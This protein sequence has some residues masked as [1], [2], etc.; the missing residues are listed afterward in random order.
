[1][2]LNFLKYLVIIVITSIWQSETIVAQPLSNQAVI[3]NSITNYIESDPDRFK[4]PNY[5]AL[6]LDGATSSSLQSLQTVLSSAGI[7]LTTDFNDSHQFRVLVSSQNRLIRLNKK[8]YSREIKGSVGIT[9]TNSGGLI[10]DSVSFNFHALDTIP[11]GYINQVQSD[12]GP[13][14]FSEITSRR[15]YSRIQ[16]FVEPV[17]ITSAVATTVYLLYNIRSQ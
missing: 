11:S 16:R 8:D 7:N 6:V 15:F 12:W 4:S 2:T 9:I 1:M 14:Q 3:F 5:Y 17:L 10:L 13:T